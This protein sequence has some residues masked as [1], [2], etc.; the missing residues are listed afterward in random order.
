MLHR[1]QFS[2]SSHEPDGDTMQQHK[3]TEYYGLRPVHDSSCIGER[4]QALDMQQQSCLPAAHL[5]LDL[6]GVLVVHC[7]A[8][9]DA[10][11]QDLLDCAPE[12]P[13]TAA[14]PHDPCDFD[15]R[16]KLEVAAVL[17]VLLLQAKPCPI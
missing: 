7:A 16:V 10:C 4:E 9:A 8:H 15:D 12:L 3:C 6:A 14:V 1:L 13:R 2:D 17:D 5:A 11:S